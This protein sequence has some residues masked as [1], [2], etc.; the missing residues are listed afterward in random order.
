MFGSDFPFVPIEV[1]AMETLGLTARELQSV[2]RD[3]ALS[4]MPRLK[5]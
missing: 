4:L 3:N 1:T 5:A 2:A